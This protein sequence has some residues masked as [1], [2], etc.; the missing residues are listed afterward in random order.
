MTIVTVYNQT[1]NFIYKLS[2]RKANH[3]LHKILKIE[4]FLVHLK[5]YKLNAYLVLRIKRSN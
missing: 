1:E 2:E 3:C 4:K 5:N